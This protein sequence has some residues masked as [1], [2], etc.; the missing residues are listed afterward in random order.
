MP[1]STPSI[2]LALSLNANPCPLH[3]PPLSIED[4]VARRRRPRP[5]RRREI[6]FGFLPLHFPLLL[7]NAPRA[8]VLL[9]YPFAILGHVLVECHLYL[10][11]LNVFLEVFD[12]GFQVFLCGVSASQS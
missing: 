5:T 1:S 2:R 11:L 9:E 4:I 12:S 6:D 10:Y 3:I 7:G 8:S